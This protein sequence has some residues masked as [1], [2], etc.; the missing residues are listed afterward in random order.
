VGKKGIPVASMV[1]SS[2][3]CGREADRVTLDNAGPCFD[4]LVEDGNQRLLPSSTRYVSYGL[5][6]NAS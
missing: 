5:H 1:G 2:C 3:C 4:S 6:Y